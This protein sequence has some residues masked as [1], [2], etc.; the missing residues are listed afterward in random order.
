MEVRILPNAQRTSS[1]GRTADSKP[2]NEGSIPSERAD[3]EPKLLG[4][5]MGNS[6]TGA[7]PFDG[8]TEAGAKYV[9]QNPQGFTGQLDA[10]PSQTG[11][12]SGTETGGSTDGNK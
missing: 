5:D 10:T 8:T 12:G 7:T 2:A 11:T 3:R 4:E 6:T 1:K 9:G